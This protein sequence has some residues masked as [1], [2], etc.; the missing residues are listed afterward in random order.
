[1]KEAV[2]EEMEQPNSALGAGLVHTTSGKRVADTDLAT[3]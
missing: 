2:M 3:L 1:M